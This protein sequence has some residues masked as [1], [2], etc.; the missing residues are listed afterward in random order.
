MPFKLLGNLIALLSLLMISGCSVN[1][2]DPP[3]NSQPADAPVKAVPHEIT[4]L[5]SADKTQQ[6][7]MFY[8]PPTKEPVPLLVALHTW[9]GDYKQTMYADSVEWCAKNGWAFIHPN[10]RGPNINPAA[11]GSEL[12]IQDIEDAVQFARQN[13]AIDEKR[14]YL[15]GV[16]GGGYTALLMAARCPHLWAGVSVWVPITNLADWY[17]ETKKA[18]QHYYKD[19]AAS[20]GGSPGTSE[21]VDEEYRK[22]SPITYLYVKSALPPLDINAGIHDGHTGSVPISHSLK[23]FNAIAAPEDRVD[24]GDIQYMVAKRAIPEDLKNPSMMS[25]TGKM[26]LYSVLFR[27]PR[28]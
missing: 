24:D 6:P 19:V 2:A 28:D 23:A 17:A 13:A 20:C 11:T 9:S 22:R 4:Y 26:P 1:A 21:A 3:M 16:S 12:V 14:I 25:P 10:F 27:V 5:S 7:A 18:S 15:V 8:A